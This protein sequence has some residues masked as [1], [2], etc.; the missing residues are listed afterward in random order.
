MLSGPNLDAMKQMK[1]AVDVPVIA[2]GGVAKAEDVSRQLAEIGYGRLH[3]WKI[4][5]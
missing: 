1:Q 2:S 4:A 3:R 5:V